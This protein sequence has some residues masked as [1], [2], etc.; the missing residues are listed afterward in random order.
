MTQPATPPII[1]FSHGQDGEPWGSKIMAMAEVARAAN[2]QVQSVDYRGMA[3]P[4]ARVDK[5]LAFCK[6]L[7]VAPVLVG[8][9][10][11]GHVAAAASRI[12]NARGLFLLAP[13]F[14][15]P[16]YEQFT[17]IPATCPISIVHGWRDAVVPVDN[18]IRYAREHRATLHLVDDEHRLATSIDAIALYLRMFLANVY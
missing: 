18:S 10:M 1:V 15:M 5:L 3:D 11:G 13:A 4:Q 8:S 14:Y 2:Y 12:V 9:S 17:P 6:T 16:G 7:I